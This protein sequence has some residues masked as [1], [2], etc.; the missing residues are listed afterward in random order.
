MYLQKDQIFFLFAHIMSLHGVNIY[1]V[2]QTP[3]TQVF[4][5][6]YPVIRCNVYTGCLDTSDI[7][8]GLSP[9]TVG[10]SLVKARG[11][12]LLD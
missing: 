10:N 6:N 5:L 11:L 3:D 9:C 8:H 12:S 1:I 4:R 2:P 7:E